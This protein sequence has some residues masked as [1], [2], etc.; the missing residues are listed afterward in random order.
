MSQAKKVAAI[1]KLE[2]PAQEASPAP[3]I[4]PALGQ[5]QVNI[6]EFCK[7]FN[8]QTKN[9]EKGVPTPVIIEVYENKKFSITIKKPT[10]SYYILKACKL[11]KGSSEAGRSSAVANITEQ[12]CLEIA[13]EKIEEMNTDK[14]ESAVKIVKGSARSMGIKVV[15]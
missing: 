3:P 5:K 13:K 11:E 8:E 12:Q 4:G 15:H 9:I 14:I 1:I 10:V 2:I 7:T 6:M